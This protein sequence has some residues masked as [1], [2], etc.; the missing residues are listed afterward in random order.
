MM[1]RSHRTIRNVCG[2]AWLLFVVSSLLAEEP[3]KPKPDD[4]ELL[5]KGDNFLRLKIEVSTEDAEK[6]KADGRPYVKGTIIE[7]DAVTYKNVGIKLKGAAGSFREFEDRPAL[8]INSDKFKKKQAF[9]GLDKFH[10]NNSVQDESYLCELICSEIFRAAGVPTPRATHARVWLNGRDVGLYVLKEGFDSRFLKRHFAKTDGNLYDG[11]FLQ[12]IDAN[13]EKDAGDGPDDHS[14]LHAIAE[15]ARDPDPNKR[16]TRVAELID[17]EAF[18]TFMAV[19]RMTCHWDGYCLNMNNYRVYF[20]PGR[21][22]A[23][24]ESNAKTPALGESGLNSRAVF[25]PHGMDQMFGDPGMGLFDHPHPLLTQL[26]MQNNALRKRYREKIR[27]LLPLFSPPDKLLARCD[28]IAARLKPVL[29]EISEEAANAHADRVRELKERITARAENL[30]EQIEQ[31]DQEPEQFEKG[32]VLKLADW[33]PASEVEDAKLEEVELPGGK[34]G[35]SITAGPSGQCVASWRRR[36]LLGAGTYKL[37]ATCR[38]KGVIPLD[39]NDNSAAGVRTSKSE[40]NTQVLGTSTKSV[41]FQFTVVED[42]REVEFVAELK[43]RKGQAIFEGDSLR[44]I[45]VKSK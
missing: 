19:E 41:E 7:N 9:H 18:L 25:F 16:A 17:I 37:V 10:L 5:F 31:P 15:A 8:T 36:V 23:P 20:D 13:L 42:R 29:A 44:L 28:N 34:K 21:A 43:A 12:D 11:G 6:I 22:I 30:K 35:L 27:S 40:R 3:A 32:G 4:S 14:D 24:G 38:T 39:D 33:N 1:D 2:L 26:V 45:K